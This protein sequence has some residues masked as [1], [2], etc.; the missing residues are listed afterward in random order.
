MAGLLNNA[1]QRFATLS[2]KGLQKTIKGGYTT[3]KED[4]RNVRY[5][6]YLLLRSYYHW[7]GRLL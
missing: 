6:W 2:K 1:D 7:K 4:E 3:H 5:G